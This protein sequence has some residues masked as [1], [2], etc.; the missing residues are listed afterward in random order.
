[1][2]VQ[3]PMNVHVRSCTFKQGATHFL[4]RRGT[5]SK[6]DE[7]NAAPLKLMEIEAEEV[8]ALEKRI[9]AERPESGSAMDDQDHFKLF[10]LS[11]RTLQ[12]L[13]KCKFQKPTKI[14]SGA[15][16]HALAG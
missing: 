7:T 2:D 1:M 14:Q 11:Q 4:K 6:T 16:P 13:R 10:P 3:Y 12:G 8:R 5:M 9:E 15:I